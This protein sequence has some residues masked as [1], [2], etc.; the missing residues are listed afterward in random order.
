LL[1]TPGFSCKKVFK[2]HSIH[3]LWAK[4]NSR[5][6]LGFVF[7]TNGVLDRVIEKMAGYQQGSKGGG[8]GYL[9]ITNG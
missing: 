4:M 8:V 6:T 3:N 7:Y 2:A 5:V 9:F 1:E